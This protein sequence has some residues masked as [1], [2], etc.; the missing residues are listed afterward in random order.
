MLKKQF[1]ATQIFPYPQRSYTVAAS[2][3]NTVVEVPIPSGAK[4]FVARTNNGVFLSRAQ[5]QF[6]IVTNIGDG[7][8]LTFCPQQ[9]KFLTQGMS[10]I[11]VGLLN[12]GDVAT[13]GF[14]FQLFD[15]NLDTSIG[16]ETVQNQHP[17]DIGVNSYAELPQ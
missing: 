9:E 15:S 13:I 11:Y 14:H 3:I 5:I 10:S 7:N 16:Q 17:A 4:F 12:V 6:P 2:V 1:G 8:S